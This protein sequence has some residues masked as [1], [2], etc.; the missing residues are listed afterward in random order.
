MEPSSEA[1]A[2]SNV[3]S[4]IAT[5]LGLV[6]I[7]V[8][9][10]NQQ[11]ILQSG[12]QQLVT[13]Q[14]LE[15][16]TSEYLLPDLSEAHSFNPSQ[17]INE[18]ISAD[19]NVIAQSMLNNSDITSTDELVMVLTDH[20]Y[21]DGNNEILNSDNSNIVVLYSHPVDGQENQFIT[22]QG[23]LML[24]SQTG[25]LEIR[26]AMP[27]TS[28]T[29]QILINPQDTH[30]ESIEMIQREINNHSAAK[31]TETSNSIEP[32]V[33]ALPNVIEPFTQNTEMLENDTTDQGKPVEDLSSS[34]IHNVGVDIEKENMVFNTYEILPDHNEAGTQ[35]ENIAAPLES[36]EN[37]E[38]TFEEVLQPP[39]E[40]S[41]EDVTGQDDCHVAEMEIDEDCK[42]ADAPSIVSYL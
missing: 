42:V 27:P 24:N 36:T 32:S 3:A 12:D 26:N 23:N 38:Q 18:V 8:L 28:T 14:A 7:V 33:T 30:M 16:T 10:D 1:E 19:H 40:N 31:P 20:D 15:N 29:S 2:L 21:N 13:Q 35:N 4:G 34:Q 17:N 41:T 9:D 22:S 39:T 11:Y 5:S 6:D 25:M 37:C